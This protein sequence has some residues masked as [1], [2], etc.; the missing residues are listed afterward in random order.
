MPF[1]TPALIPCVIA[2]PRPAPPRPTQ[3]KNLYYLNPLALLTVANIPFAKTVCVDGCPPA[4]DV[5]DSR[6]L[7]CTN[8]SQLL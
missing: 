5:C 2:P 7:P 4:A 8:N 6:A 3:A 1:P